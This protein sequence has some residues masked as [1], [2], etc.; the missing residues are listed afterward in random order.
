[1]ARAVITCTRARSVLIG[2][3]SALKEGRP[4]AE[5]TK[6][7]AKILVW[8]STLAGYSH[9]ISGVSV[10]NI[11]TLHSPFFLFATNAAGRIQ[12]WRNL[13]DDEG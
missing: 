13:S 10:P 9:P 8:H 2:C 11:L 12:Q 1:M 5:S 6:E 7:E 4:T 3:K